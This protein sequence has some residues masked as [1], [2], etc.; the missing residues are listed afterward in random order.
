M[1]DTISLRG[2]NCYGTSETALKLTTIHA[3]SVI[4][5]MVPSISKT[6]QL[7]ILVVDLMNAAASTFYWHKVYSYLFKKF[8][9]KELT[10]IDILILTTCLVQHSEVVWDLI[11]EVSMMSVAN[12]YLDVNTVMPWFCSFHLQVLAFMWGHS[13]V[14]GCGI[15]IYRIMLIKHQHLVHHTIGR[16]NLSILSYF[17]KCC[18]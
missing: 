6:L 8:K 11:L 4:S 7:W 16:K 17:E 2:Y 10:S 3:K 13:V 14:G 12:G 15:A 5:P 9:R 1:N 18:Y